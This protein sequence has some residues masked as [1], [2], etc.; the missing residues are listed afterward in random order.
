MKKR[1]EL[2][3]S[4]KAR[5]GGTSLETCVSNSNYSF[6]DYLFYYVSIHEDC[7]LDKFISLLSS[8]YIDMMGRVANSLDEIIS[9]MSEL[10]GSIYDSTKK[11]S[12]R[13]SKVI[14]LPVELIEDETGFYRL[15][16][17]G[18]KISCYISYDPESHTVSFNNQGLQYLAPVSD[19]KTLQILKEKIERNKKTVE[20]LS[21]KKGMSLFHKADYEGEI[22]IFEGYIEDDKKS[23]VTIMDRYAILQLVK[24]QME[25]NPELIQELFGDLYRLNKIMTEKHFQEKKK[26]DYN[27][28]DPIIVDDYLSDTLESLV[29]N[30][31]ISEDTFI[32]VFEE[33]NKIDY[34]YSRKVYDNSFVPNICGRRFRLLLTWFL[35]EVYL[36]SQ[37]KR[38][39][40][41]TESPM[42]LSRKKD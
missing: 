17:Q 35:E 37:D 25:R 33:I 7:E 19:D 27:D 36:V 13:L 8:R 29:K 32:K 38:G 5:V 2:A 22:K 31:E 23:Y 28:Y 24:N 10:N 39:C 26:E 16:L 4:A 41:H 1:E 20:S 18:V 6:I 9:A 40:E 12:E 21:V 34:L 42:N 30:N 3:S 14:G 15:E 11:L